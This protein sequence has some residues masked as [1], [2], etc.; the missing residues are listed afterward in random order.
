MRASHLSVLLLGAAHGCSNILI[1]PGASADGNSMIAYNADSAS[2]HGAISH[3][4]G[5][6][7]PPGA[8][9]DV[10]SWD[11]GRCACE[12]SHSAHA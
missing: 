12:G 7:H 5:G 8:M 3:W 4:P 10:Y 6:S 9:R 1:T 11:L 2:L